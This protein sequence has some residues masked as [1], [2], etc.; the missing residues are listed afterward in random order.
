MSLFLWCLGDVSKFWLPTQ[1]GTELFPEVTRVPTRLRVIVNGEA[2]P[3]AVA[4]QVA[5][6]YAAE[7]S[8]FHYAQAQQYSLSLIES[9]KAQAEIAPGVIAI[10]NNQ[11]GVEYLTLQVPYV[12]PRL[13][14]AVAPEPVAPPRLILPPEPFVSEVDQKLTS[15]NQSARL[16]DEIIAAEVKAT[17]ALAL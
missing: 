13:E 16:P 3:Q 9:Y 11:Q 8:R 7:L 10:Y 4:S 2:A 6:D 15:L 14:P 5:N 12:R 1:K 17:P